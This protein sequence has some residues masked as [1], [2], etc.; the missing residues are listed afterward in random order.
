[1]DK[2]KFQREFEFWCGLIGT[3]ALSISAAVLMLWWAMG[4]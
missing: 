2:D 4:K 1:M 3:I